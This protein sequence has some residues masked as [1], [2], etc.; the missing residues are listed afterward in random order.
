MNQWECKLRLKF[1]RRLF[2]RK[3]GFCFEWQA[4]LIAYDV[5][6]VKPD[7]FMKK[8]PEEQMNASAYG[9]AIWFCI[10]NRRRIFFTYKD[11]VKALNKSSMAKS[12][13]IEKT[14]KFAQYPG[15]TR[16]DK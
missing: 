11:L 13:K 5:L 16:A 8:D 10:N 6:D 15:W 2:K 4:W 9:G 3:I 7:E 12:R 14:L 1:P